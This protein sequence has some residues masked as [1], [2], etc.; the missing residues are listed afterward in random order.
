[1][2]GDSRLILIS[3][4][5]AGAERPLRALLDSGA[6]NNFIRDDCL[7]L[8]LSHVR[9]REGP[10]EIVVKLADGKPHRAPRRAVSLAYAFDSFFTNDDFLVIELN[11]AFDCILRMPW[12]ARYQPEIDWLARSVRRRVGYDVSEVFAHLL[13]APS[14]HVAVVDRTST[15]QPPQR[16]SDGPRC[17]ECAASVI[18]PVS[19]P[20][21]SAREGLKKNTVEQWFPCER[22]AV[23]Q[24]LPHKK[25]AV[26]QRLPHVKNA[27]EQRLPPVQNV[28]EQRFPHVK[29]AVEQRLPLENATVEQRLPF[30]EDS[31]AQQDLRDT[32]MVET[33]LP[34]ISEGEVSSS[35]S[36]SS[37]TSASSSGSRRLRKSKRNRPGRRRL[38]RRFT[39]VDQAPSSEI[40]SVV[41]YSEGS[42]NQV[43][44]IEVANPPTDAATI[45]RL[46]GLSWKHFLR[47]LKAGEIE[48]VCLLTGSDQPDVLASAVSDDASSSRLKAAE[49]KSVREARFAAQSWQALQDSNNPVY[50]LAREFEDIFPEKIPAELLYRGYTFG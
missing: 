46:P 9:V 35:E 33:E 3:L 50:S 49:P 6:T 18:G 44:A 15:T 43:R 23:K 40:L 20:P 4:H 12:L 19:N 8:L 31:V 25:K 14:L 16:E 37:E 7:A 32:G 27:V 17:V 30:A 22:N 47:D 38:R 24:R 42:P 1:M 10:G 34:C 26:E 48:Q 39:A 45:T 21:S 2:N 5:V 28:V 29:N 36:S 13:V 41:E 11:Y